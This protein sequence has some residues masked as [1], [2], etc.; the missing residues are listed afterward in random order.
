MI[1]YPQNSVWS[2]RMS[3][4]QRLSGLV[5][6]FL[7]L[8]MLPIAMPAASASIPSSTP[9]A[10]TP[11]TY[12][13]T[14]AQEGSTAIA[15]DNDYMLVGDDNDNLL[16]LYDRRPSAPPPGASPLSQTDFTTDLGVGAKVDIEGSTK[17]GSRIYWIGSHSNG[18][19]SFNF[20]PDRQRLFATDLVGTGATTTLNFL[21]HYDNLRTDTGG[22]LVAW[23]DVHGYDFT[24][25]IQSGVDPETVGGFNIEGLT[26]A[27][28]STT[29]Y[30]GF[31]APLVGPNTDKALIAPVANV[32]D[33]VTGKSVSATIGNPI[34]LDLGGR[35]IRSIERNNANEYLIVAGPP[36]KI[37]LSPS[38]QLYKWTGKATD[39]PVSLNVDM[40][41]LDTGGGSFEGIIE[42]P[43]PLC[44]TTPI[45]LV[46]DNGDQNQ[47]Y[48]RTIEIPNPCAPG[49]VKFNRVF[50][51][52]MENK[53]DTALI[54]S[55]DAPYINSLV[56]QYPRSTNYYAI[57]HPSFP[58]Y[59]TLTA[60]R[61][62]G[63]T[64]DCTLT[65][66]NNA[67]LSSA[68]NL[69]NQFEIAGVSWKAYMETMPSPCFPGAF[70]PSNTD[71]KY[72]QKHNPF[73]YYDNIRNNPA[74][75]N[76]IVP[77]EQF[78]QDVGNNALPEFVWIT[79]N[80]V[81]DMHGIGGETPSQRIKN[82]DDW[83]KIWVPQILA[84]QAWQEG[85]L[86]VIT[87]DEGSSTL[88]CCGFD[89]GGGRI[90]TLLISRL[91]KPC[92]RSATPYNHYSLFRTI[93]ENWGLPLLNH[94][95][96]AGI[97]SMSEFFTYSPTPCFEV[98]LPLI[99]R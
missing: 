84:S 78:A 81:N 87:F 14:G 99:G 93:E 1:Q 15:L 46:V 19:N 27:P 74:R 24:A 44:S 12:Y 59:L 95:N 33:L 13:H 49:P 6:L 79:P 68:D 25:K 73:I 39:T 83:L 57:T 28:D 71:P 3:R 62:F 54:D 35:G 29:A 21:G 51:I 48:F 63:V 31:R 26:M 90:L 96:D 88:G 98:N 18:G 16:R 7:L 2:A 77:F 60:G 45:Q 22:D 94:A 37:G 41:A 42:V 66:C 75:C 76:K 85:G 89:P 5:A 17:V 36:M 34:E 65:T 97:Q 64:N 53:E 80:Q 9:A 38:F 8:A 61:T 58:N 11:K 23:G 92:Y 72:A 91:S 86:L 40:A 32:D 20:R 43:T 30:I 52:V 50:V 82:G 70:Y 55:I 67:A 10:S 4:K 69:A 56:A 47:G